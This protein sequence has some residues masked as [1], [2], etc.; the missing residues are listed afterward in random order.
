MNP[1]E[2]LGL[3]KSC[4]EQDIKKAYKKLSLLYHPDRNSGDPDASE[5]FDQCTKAYELLS[6]QK[7]RASYDQGGWD[8]VNH[9]SN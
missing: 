6:D 9:I 2:I 3:Q 8:Y 4:N 7:L 1:Y 5:K